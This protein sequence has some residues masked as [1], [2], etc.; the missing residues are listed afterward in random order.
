MDEQPRQP[1]ERREVVERHES[2]ERG[3]ESTSPTPPPR[4]RAASWIWEGLVLLVVAALA[5]YALSRGEPQE[6]EMP[7][8]EAPQIEVPQDQ[9]D[10]EINVPEAGA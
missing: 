7:D 2:V 8:I 10:I 6:L 1:V 5:W 4:S 3:T 9:P